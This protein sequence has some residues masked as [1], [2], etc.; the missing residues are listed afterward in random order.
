MKFK[1]NIKKK[2]FLAMFLIL[3]IDRNIFV[4][5]NRTFNI[6]NSIK[7][8]NEVRVTVAN[9]MYCAMKNMNDKMQ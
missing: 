1:W 5:T 6:F 7:I 3:L 9:A 4:S 8:G 2:E